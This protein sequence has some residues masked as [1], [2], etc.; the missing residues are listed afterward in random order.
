MNEKQAG[1]HTYFPPLPFEFGLRVNLGT[2][3]M[4]LCRSVLWGFYS[5]IGSGNRRKQSE[6]D[7]YTVAVLVKSNA[8]NYDVNC[9]FFFV[10]YGHMITTQLR[11][12][13]IDALA[14]P[15]INHHHHELKR[16]HRYQRPK[17]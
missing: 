3:K 12:V 4:T 9:T 10:R 2:Q 11:G 5:N 16:D 14:L 6:I 1:P 13:A 7:P 8:T 15:V 17:H